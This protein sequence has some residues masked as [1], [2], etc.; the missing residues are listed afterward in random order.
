MKNASSE[1]IFPPHS[2]TALFE[3][4]CLLKYI[5]VSFRSIPLYSDPSL[6]IPIHPSLFRSIP[7]IVI[8]IVIVVTVIVVVVVVIVIVIVIVVV[9]V[10]AVVVI[11]VIIDVL[12]DYVIDLVPSTCSLHS[13]EEDGGGVEKNGPKLMKIGE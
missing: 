2:S 12:T 13:N 8:V 1:S 5:L 4:A 11:F 3:R 7:F 10:A 6:F 9:V